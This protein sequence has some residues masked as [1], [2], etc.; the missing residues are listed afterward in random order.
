MDRLP[1]IECI[2]DARTWCVRVYGGLDG[3]AAYL[4]K[5]GSYVPFE[6]KGTK[7][8]KMRVFT[9]RKDVQA[10]VEELHMNTAEKERLLAKLRGGGQPLNVNA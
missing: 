1:F 8:G 10:A 5:D 2:R 6:G 4:G 7:G 3:Q 9:R